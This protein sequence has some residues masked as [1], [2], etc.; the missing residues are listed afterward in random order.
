M[1]DQL[2]RLRLSREYYLGKKHAYARVIWLVDR[3]A[4]D[5]IRDLIRTAREEAEFYDREIAK[6]EES[7]NSK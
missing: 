5:A 4:E 3:P 6:I 2:E 7:L 1:K